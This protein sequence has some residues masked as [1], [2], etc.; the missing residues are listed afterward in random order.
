MILTDRELRHSLETGG[1]VI[2][3]RPAEAAFGPTSIDLRLHSR[4]RVFRTPET[5]E[6]TPIDPAA[7]GY[8]FAEAIDKITSPIEITEQGFLLAPQQLVL[9][10]TLETVLLDPNSRLVGRLE[11][12]SALARIGLAVHVTAP[13]IHAGSS[14]QIQLEIVNH[15]PRPIV[16]RRA[17]RI[18]QFIVEQTLGVPDQVYRGQFK[19]QLG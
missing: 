4:L 10:W 13:T 3:P 14:G 1:V 2:E 15:G 5:G 19:G 6:A 8:V 11:G 16:L 18:C 7:D 9:A 12:K 17:M